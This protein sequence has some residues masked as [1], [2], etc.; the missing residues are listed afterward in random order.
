MPVDAGRMLVE[1]RN[2]SA[3]VD[4]MTTPNSEHARCHIFLHCD[5]QLFSSLPG[6]ARLVSSTIRPTIGVV[7]DDVGRVGRTPEFVLIMGTSLGT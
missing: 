7:L 1:S 4:M 3:R 5:F 2:Q 6:E